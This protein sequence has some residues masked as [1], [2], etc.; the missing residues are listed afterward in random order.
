[1]YIEPG[2]DSISLLVESEF[3]GSC[4]RRGAEVTWVGY[5]GENLPVLTDSN[6]G[7]VRRYNSVN[8][9]QFAYFSNALS[10]QAFC[11]I[12]S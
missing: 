11:Y 4:Y 7:A 8:M 5:E 12:C 9:S 1:M 10:T 2:L 6:L 3:D